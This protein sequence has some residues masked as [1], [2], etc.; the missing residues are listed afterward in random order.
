MNRCL[1]FLMIRRPPRS[2]LTDTLFPYTTLVRSDE[3]AG[4]LRAEQHRHRG[5][6]D[7]R[8][9]RLDDIEGQG[10]GCCALEPAGVDEQA[11]AAVRAIHLQAL[12]DRKSTR[13][14]SS[15]YCDPRMPSSA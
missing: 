2:T 7:A 4:R 13:L 14:N 9:R 6:A 15:H 10:H 11:E 3:S 12:P 8:S 5:D 1:L